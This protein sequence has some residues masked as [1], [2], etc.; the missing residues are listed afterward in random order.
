LTCD[1]TQHWTRRS[2]ES[3]GASGACRGKDGE[4]C[5]PRLLNKKNQEN[6]VIG[7]QTVDEEEDS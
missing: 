3:E 2:G 1:S 6:R 4:A 7:L 5:L